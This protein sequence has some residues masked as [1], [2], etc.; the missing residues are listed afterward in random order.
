MTKK[1]SFREIESGCVAVEKIKAVSNFRKDFNEEKL[2][3]LADNIAKVGVLQ[4][5]ILRRDKEDLVLVAGERRL[6][7][8]KMAGL[9]EIPYRLLDLSEKEAVEV[10]G[11]VEKFVFACLA[12]KA[13]VWLIFMC[14]TAWNL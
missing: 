14:Y 8:A 11:I 7:A 10:C 3:E 5:V 13:V 2:K 4:P 1:K 6:R 9:T 12:F